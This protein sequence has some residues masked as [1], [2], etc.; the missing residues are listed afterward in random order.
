MVTRSRG[1]TDF[2]NDFD[3]NS[4]N[5]IESQEETNER[6]RNSMMSIRSVTIIFQFPFQPFHF[7]LRMVNFMCHLDR[8]ERWTDNWPNAVLVSARAWPRG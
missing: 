4:Q 6:G 8:A 1:L 7:G 5:D 2:K 3:V